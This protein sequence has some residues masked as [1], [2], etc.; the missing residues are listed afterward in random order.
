MIKFT[1][2]NQNQERKL[3]RKPKERRRRAQI[4]IRESRGFLINRFY[5]PVTSAQKHLKSSENLIC[6]LLQVLNSIFWEKGCSVVAKELN[7]LN[8]VS[9][10]ALI[11][12]SMANH[13][14]GFW[15]IV[16]KVH[17][18]KPVHSSYQPATSSCIMHPVIDEFLMLVRVLTCSKMTT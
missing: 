11:W 12:N 13:W 5:Y 3:M 9:T 4:W 7:F 16:H 2:R 10:V 8:D 14:L 6:W 17:P 15:V 1:P 18:C